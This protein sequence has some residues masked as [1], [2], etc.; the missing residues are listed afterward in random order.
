MTRGEAQ[1][2]PCPRISRDMALRFWPPVLYRVHPDRYWPVKET[3]VRWQGAPQKRL[4][5]RDKA[6]LCITPWS[7]VPSSDFATLNWLTYSDL[8]PLK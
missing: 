5:I 2:R 4:L 7:G 6:M 8:A 1:C 3:A